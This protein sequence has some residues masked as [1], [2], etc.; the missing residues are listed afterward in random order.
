MKFFTVLVSA[1]LVAFAAA[2]SSTSSQLP[3]PSSSYDEKTTACLDA[4]SPRDVACYANCLHAPAPDESQVNETTKCA[5][6]CEQ[7]DGSAEQTEAYGKCQRACVEQHFLPQTSGGSSGPRP[8][9]DATGTGTG[10]PSPTGT[11]NDTNNGNNTDG[12][13][14]GGGN[15][16]A[17]SMV[18]SASFAGLIAAFVAA[19]AL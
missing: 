11:G 13:N 15:S 8:T 1:G 10:R 2:Q 16:A 9:G 7:G 17:S 3:T 18:Y 19:L 12:G 6:A 5:A 4:C 14:G